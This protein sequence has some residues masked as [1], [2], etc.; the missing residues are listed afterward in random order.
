MILLDATRSLTA[1]CPAGRPS[2]P[3]V[4]HAIH[5]GLK[6]ARASSATIH[7]NRI[8]FEGGVFR[9]VSRWNLLLSICKGKVEVWTSGNGIRMEYAL[10]FRELFVVSVAMSCFL[11][12][13]AARPSGATGRS[14]AIFGLVVFSFFF[15]VNRVIALV[16][17][18][19]FLKKCVK[20][21]G[22]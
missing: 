19:A 7:E 5:Q 20:D 15:F 12:V 2:V 1:P 22:G 9:W 13:A 10:S 16:R 8:E 14:A 17:F 6:D 21:A 4:V 18:R 3:R 11:G